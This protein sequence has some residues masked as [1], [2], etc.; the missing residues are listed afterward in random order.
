MITSWSWPRAS[1]KSKGHQDTVAPNPAISTRGGWVEL[2][3]PNLPGRIHVHTIS[4]DTQAALQSLLPLLPS[5]S[6]VTCNDGIRGVGK[7]Q[8]PEKVVDNFRRCPPHRLSLW[9][10]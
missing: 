2:S 1:R 5:F 4:A 8:G 10:P 9:H 3:L 7:Q 6:L